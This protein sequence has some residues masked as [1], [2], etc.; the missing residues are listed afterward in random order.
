MRITD[1]GNYLKYT[2]QLEIRLTGAGWFVMPIHV[3][4]SSSERVMGA[5]LQ[6]AETCCLRSKNTQP[7]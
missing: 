6:A 5:P 7:E 1:E 2:S 4:L 3:K